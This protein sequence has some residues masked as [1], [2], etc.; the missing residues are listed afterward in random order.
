L[1]GR[2]LSRDYLVIAPNAPAGAAPAAN[3]YV[4]KSINMLKELLETLFRNIDNAVPNRLCHAFTIKNA[5]G[6]SFSS[7][8]SSRIQRGIAPRPDQVSSRFF[9]ERCVGF[10]FVAFVIERASIFGRIY[11]AK[12]LSNGPFANSV[13]R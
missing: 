10:G 3:P 8:I 13:R 12:I 2:G 7:F 1:R 4:T 11:A 6:F 9:F 5:S